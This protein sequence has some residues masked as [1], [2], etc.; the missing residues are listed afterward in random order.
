MD[1]YGELISRRGRPTGEIRSDDVSVPDVSDYDPPRLTSKTWRQ[2]IHKVWEVD[3][4]VCIRCGAEMKIIALIDDPAVIRLRC[5]L[6]A[7]LVFGEGS[8][9]TNVEALT[10]EATIPGHSPN[11]GVWIRSGRR[12]VTAMGGGRR[13]GNMWQFRRC[14]LVIRDSRQPSDVPTAARS[15]VRQVRPKLEGTG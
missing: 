12:P 6:R 8:P 2:L 10:S 4:M 13:V 11:P 14:P 5:G 9:S 3:P 15:E 7:R 1:P